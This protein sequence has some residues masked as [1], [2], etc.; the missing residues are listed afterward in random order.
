MKGIYNEY[1]IILNKTKDFVNDY[2]I[3]WQS[4]RKRL[5]DRSYGFRQTLAAESRATVAADTGNGNGRFHTEYLKYIFM[6]LSKTMRN[7][8]LIYN[9]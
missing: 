7:P 3:E 5:F 1:K 8:F 2:L 6:F 9:F 4:F